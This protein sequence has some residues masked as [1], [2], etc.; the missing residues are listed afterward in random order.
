[1]VIADA[2]YLASYTH[3]A[4]QSPT[5]FPLLAPQFPY[6]LS[7]PTEEAAFGISTAAGY[8]RRALLVSGL[9]R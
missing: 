1:M 5:P 9:R 6:V 3:K 2:A 4:Y 7:L 8:A